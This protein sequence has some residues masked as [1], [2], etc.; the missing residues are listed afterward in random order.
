MSEISVVQ[1]NPT[2]M[3]RDHGGSA[4]GDWLYLAGKTVL[5]WQQEEDH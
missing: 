3:E 1:M 2:G 4:P 5:R